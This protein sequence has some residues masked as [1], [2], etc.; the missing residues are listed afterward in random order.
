MSERNR[1]G[2]AGQKRQYFQSNKHQTIST[3]FLRQLL[4][5][6]FV[7]GKGALWKARQFGGGGPCGSTRLNPFV[8]LSLDIS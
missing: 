3:T 8:I 1:H 2:V 4:P 7:P 6:S 5:S